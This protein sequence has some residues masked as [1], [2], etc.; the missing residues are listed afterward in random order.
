MIYLFLI[1]DF[2]Q[3]LIEL[4]TCS[5]NI[6]TG[7]TCEARTGEE[8][9]LLLNTVAACTNITFYACKGRTH[10]CAHILSVK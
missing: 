1:F 6:S 9:E 2:N 5:N 10:V 4:A 8:E 7:D 3:I